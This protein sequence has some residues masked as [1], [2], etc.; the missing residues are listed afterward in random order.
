M[1]CGIIVPRQRQVVGEREDHY[2]AEC[3][4]RNNHAG[5]HVFRTPEGDHVAW[6]DDWEC[7]CCEPEE[8]ERCISYWEIKESDILNLSK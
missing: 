8:D 7:G 4:L 3:I 2:L 5:P 1:V 6:E